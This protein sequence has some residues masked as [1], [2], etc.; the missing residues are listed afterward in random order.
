MIYYQEDD[1]KDMIIIVK[2]EY[3]NDNQVKKTQN[4]REKYMRFT[5]KTD[6]KDLIIDVLRHQVFL[7]GKKIILTTLEFSLL[8]L[9]ASQPERVYTYEQIYESVWGEPYNN[10]KGNIMTHINHIRNK[11]ELNPDHHQYIENIRGVGYRFR[12]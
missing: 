3:G 10:E 2:P 8:F 6:N 5:D 9:L 11:I 1:C 12:K 4:V 7:D